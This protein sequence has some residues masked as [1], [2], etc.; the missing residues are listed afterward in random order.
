MSHSPN[1]I[2][3]AYFQNLRA[4]HPDWHLETLFQDFAVQPDDKILV[5]RHE[6]GFKSLDLYGGYGCAPYGKVF[7]RRQLQGQRRQE[8][9]RERGIDCV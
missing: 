7:L 8:P 6:P 3:L 2:V 5:A 1:S 9:L 4:I